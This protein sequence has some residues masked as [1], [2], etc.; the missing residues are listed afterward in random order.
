MGYR[1]HEQR[2]IPSCWPFK[3]AVELQYVRLPSNWDAWVGKLAK[4]CRARKHWGELCYTAQKA[5]A[6]TFKLLL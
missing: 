1:A 2:K 5:E 3:G 4:R 6:A